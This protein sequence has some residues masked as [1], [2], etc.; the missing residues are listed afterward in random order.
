MENDS[1]TRP[2]DPR[3]KADV[4]NFPRPE[5][6]ALTPPERWLLVA[7]DITCPMREAVNALEYVEG[8]TTLLA[9]ADN[10]NATMTPGA[11]EFFEQAIFKARQ[12]LDEALKR[13]HAATQ[14][15]ELLVPDDRFDFAV[16]RELWASRERAG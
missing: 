12:Q 10:D 4:T 16:I 14:G 3:Q 2:D 1:T 5:P 15:A 11:W 6:Q 9:S 8:L 13:V 7:D